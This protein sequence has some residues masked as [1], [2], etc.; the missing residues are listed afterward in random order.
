[1][2]APP[3]RPP[4]R[5]SFEATPWH[6]KFSKEGNGFLFYGQFFNDLDS[7]VRHHMQDKGTLL[8][9]LARPCCSY[10]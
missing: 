8:T 7:L 6:Y 9:A 5:R 4:A 10:A 3:A 2:A 1:M